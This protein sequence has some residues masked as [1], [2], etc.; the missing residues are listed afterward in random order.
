M[1]LIVHQ[2][3]ATALLQHWNTS[4]ASVQKIRMGSCVE[5]VTLGLMQREKT[6]VGPRTG[7]SCFLSFFVFFFCC[8]CCCCCCYC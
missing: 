2:I 4:E 7:D 3:G 6:T 1:A 5:A 8:C